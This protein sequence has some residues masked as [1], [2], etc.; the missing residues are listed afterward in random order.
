[1]KKFILALMLMFSCS[2]MFGQL[3]DYHGIPT[4]S[5]NVQVSDG[6]GEIFLDA[7]VTVL[8]AAAEAIVVGTVEGMIGTESGEP[9]TQW[10]GGFPTPYMTLGYDYHFPGTR[11]NVGGELGY[12]Q[13]TSRSVNRDPVITRRMNFASAAATGKFFYKPDGVCKLYGGLNAGILVLGTDSGEPGFIPA[14]QVNPIGMRLGNENVAF[15]AELGAGYRGILQ[16]G[17]NVSL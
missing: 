2:T 5:L 1:M 10:D 13:C 15:I 6:I 14:V 16:L 9:V 11:W 8:G 12:W 4:H 7:F 3:F 17:V